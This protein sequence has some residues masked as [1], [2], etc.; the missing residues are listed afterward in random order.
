M[1]ALAAANGDENKL[2]IM[3]AETES[4]TAE[5]NQAIIPQYADKHFYSWWNKFAKE[6]PDVYD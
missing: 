2:G 4:K 6:Q 3:D 1:I 5:M